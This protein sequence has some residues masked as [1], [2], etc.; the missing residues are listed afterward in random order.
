MIIHATAADAMQT[1]TVEAGAYPAELIKLDGPRPSTSGKGVNVFLEIQITDGKYK[2]KTFRIAGSS[3]SSGD[4]L[5]GDMQWFPTNSLF[6]RLDAAVN[7]TKVDTT[8]KDIDTDNLMH[9]PFDI[10]VGVSTVEGKLVN[11]ITAFA[12]LGSATSGPGF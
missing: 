1:I 9:K 10:V 5:L 6:L 12:P 11:V 8:E 3:G 7:K 2:G 4:S